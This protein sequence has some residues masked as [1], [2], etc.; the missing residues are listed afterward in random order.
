LGRPGQR[1]GGAQLGQLLRPGG[2]A[3]LAGSLPQRTGH[4]GQQLGLVAGLLQVVLRPETQPPRRLAAADPGGE[5][6]HR[7]VAQVGVV[8]HPLEGGHAVED[9]HVHVQEHQVRLHARHI[10]SPTSPSGA[11]CTR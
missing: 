9:R 10:A 2:Q 6:Q 5:E 7:E 1:V 11:S 4:A 3:L 8:L